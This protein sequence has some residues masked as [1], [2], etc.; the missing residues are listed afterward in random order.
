M[1][2]RI[3][4]D[5]ASGKKDFFELNPGARGIEKFNACSSRQMLFVCFVADRDYDSPLRT[6][7]EHQRRTKAALYSGYG[8]EG[9]RPDKNARN[10]IN[11]KIADVE[12]AITEYR[13]MQWDEERAMLDAIN[14]Q[15]QETLD[16]MALDKRE[17]ARVVKTKTEKKTGNVEKIEYVDSKLLTDLRLG[18]AKLGKELPQLRATKKQLLESIRIASPV[19]EDFITYS[20]QDVSDEDVAATENGELSTIDILNEKRF[21]Q[22]QE[23]GN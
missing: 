10:L 1:L 5:I 3:H 7:P 4:S 8:M 14:A 2:F 19:A 17:A 6:L 9:D 20:S 12:A 18:A 21:K 22:Q 16:A 15:I 13:E 23:N 11:K